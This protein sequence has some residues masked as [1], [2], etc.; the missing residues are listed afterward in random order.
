M[1]NG[2][3]VL[4]IDPADV[5]F[6]VLGIDPGVKGA[7]ARVFWDGDRGG[8][9]LGFHSGLPY[10]ETGVWPRRRLDCRALRSMEPLAGGRVS[11]VCVEQQQFRG[12]QGTS[13]YVVGFNYGLLL[14]TLVSGG[15]DVHEVSA[16][17]WK[18]D[19]GLSGGTKGDSVRVFEEVFGGSVVVREG[20]AEAALVGWW[21]LRRLRGL[22]GL[23][24]D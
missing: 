1:D 2:F 9:R 8:P 22:R 24:G 5:D 23:R 17:V 14:G 21:R 20:V 16:A 18:R 7:V 3:S 13:Q 11:T 4:G 10:A 19:M 6:A 12:T 15:W